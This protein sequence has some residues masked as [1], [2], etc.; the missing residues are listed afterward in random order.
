[1]EKEFWLEKWNEDSIGFHQSK[2]HPILK[3]KIRLFNERDLEKTILVP[4]CGKTLDMIFLKEQGF[5]VIGSE[6]SEKAC[7]DFYKEN[8]IEFK[9]SNKDGFIVFESKMI[10]LYCGDY[11]KLKLDKKIS[12]LYDRAAIVAL[13]PKDRQKYADKHTELLIPSG[14]ALLLS[15]EYDQCLCSGP[16]FSI[17]ESLIQEYFNNGFNIELIENNEIEIGNPRMIEAGVKKAI[18]KAYLLNRKAAQ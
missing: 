18:Q 1:M 6:F 14:K 12:Y 11:F 9:R 4:L 17:E 5:K 3:N 7:L 13:D 16:P 15:F 10:N 8:N 2:Y